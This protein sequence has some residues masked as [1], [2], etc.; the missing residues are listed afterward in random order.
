M[1]NYEEAKR[2]NGTYCVSFHHE[3]SEVDSTR[4]L[5]RFII[6]EG[7]K[8]HASAEPRRANRPEDD[9]RC[10]RVSLP[11]L[12]DFAHRFMLRRVQKD[13]SASHSP[14]AQQQSGRSSSQLSSGEQT[15]IN[16]SLPLDTS[17]Y[18]AFSFRLFFACSSRDFTFDFD[19]LLVDL[20]VDVFVFVFVRACALFGIRYSTNDDV[21]CW[22]SLFSFTT[23]CDNDHLQISRSPPPFLRT[24]RPEFIQLINENSFRSTNGNVSYT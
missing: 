10:V 12:P 15:A 22:L 21:G 2:F 18:T 7:T 20:R 9:T 5:S 24:F 4:P 8:Q 23:F 19:V 13:T 14:A 1:G 3:H 17:A 16:L 6:R 11:F